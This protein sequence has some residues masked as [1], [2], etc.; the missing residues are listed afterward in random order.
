[1]QHTI[2]DSRDV[3][4]ADIDYHGNSRQVA[5]S[6]TQQGDYEPVLMDE[7]RPV[8][9]DQDE[10]ENEDDNENVEECSEEEEMSSVQCSSLSS[11]EEPSC[12]PH[13]KAHQ[14]PHCP[15]STKRVQHLRYHIRTHTGDKPYS[16]KKCG[17]RFSRSSHCSR[18]M[19]RKHSATRANTY[20]GT[21][22]SENKKHQCPHCPYSTNIDQHLVYHI[23]THTGE[24]PYSCKECGRCFS[25]T[26]HRNAHMRRIHSATDEEIAALKVSRT[27]KKHQCPHCPYSARTGQH[28]RYHIR[29]HTGEKP[30]SCKEC[31]RC[32]ARPSHY[33]RHMGR[34]HSANS[35]RT[36][37]QPVDTPTP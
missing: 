12:Q 22:V 9:E 28:L 23:R 3:G 27:K 31:G 14:C 21:K 37:A 5:Q 32:F 13:T 25:R 36:S 35:T 30:Y 15:Y 8:P 4:V 1:M 26:T 33:S 6:S 11:T 16:C 18:H 19:R 7:D 34:K 2:Q 17:Q 20:R 24:K 29:T 10:S